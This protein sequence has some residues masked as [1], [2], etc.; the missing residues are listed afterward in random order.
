MAKIRYYIVT[1]GR[2]YIAPADIKLVIANETWRSVLKKV[3]ILNL[4]K[5]L[6]II[7]EIFISS[8]TAIVTNTFNVYS[9]KI[10]RK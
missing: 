9:S 4:C 5:C 1:S 7:K 6:L 8:T 10:M 2:V 3:F